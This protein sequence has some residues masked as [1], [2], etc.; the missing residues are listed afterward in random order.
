MLKCYITN[1]MLGQD[2]YIYRLRAACIAQPEYNR[3]QLAALDRELAIVQASKTPQEHLERGGYMIGL[4]RGAAL[5]RAANALDIARRYDDPWSAAAAGIE[6]VHA[7]QG[8]DHIELYTSIQMGHDRAVVLRTQAIEIHSEILR[9]FL[10]LLHVHT[11]NYQLDA[12]YVEIEE[13]FRNLRNSDPAFVPYTWLEQPRYRRRLPWHGDLLHEWLAPYWD[14][15]ANPPDVP[16]DPGE[17]PTPDGGGGEWPDAEPLDAVPDTTLAD[18]YLERQRV[19]PD[20]GLDAFWREAR[21]AALPVR[22]PVAQYAVA[23][24][25]EA[26]FSIELARN[27]LHLNGMLAPLRAIANHGWEETEESRSGIEKA[28]ETAIALTGYTPAEIF[29]LPR[30]WH[31]IVNN[32]EPRLNEGMDGFGAMAGEG[33]FDLVRHARMWLEA[34]GS[35]DFDL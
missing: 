32:L 16:A 9:L 20:E 24:D 23:C 31:F 13:A 30:V 2:H 14:D 15:A 35:I 26:R 12:A 11:S 17:L 4:A 8:N 3:Y 28:A 29:A 21:N 34:K 22:S 6:F 25:C 10:N 19:W 7:Q 18:L 1:G 33:G 5:D 27:M